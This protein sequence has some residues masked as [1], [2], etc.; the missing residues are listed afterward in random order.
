MFGSFI[1]L[2]DDNA[3]HRTLVKR[4]IAKAGIAYSIVE[5]GSLEEARTRLF[6]KDSNVHPII[7]IVD[8]NLGDGRGTTLIAELRASSSLRDLPVLVLSTSPLENDMRESYQQGA[9]CYLTKADD[10]SKFTSEIGA[11]VRFL[12]EIVAQRG[13]SLQA[14][15]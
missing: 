2:V 9:S 12:V 4:A 13:D 15:G 6:G 14:T 8:L 5:A 10:V 3:A 7:T 1:F 11:A